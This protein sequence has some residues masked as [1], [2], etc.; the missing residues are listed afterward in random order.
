MKH[1]FFIVLLGLL[2]LLACQNQAPS[3]NEDIPYQNLRNYYFPIDQAELAQGLIYE[4]TEKHSQ[5]K[6]YW[7]LKV[8][9]DEDDVQHLVTTIYNQALEQ[10]SLNR[11]W[12]SRQGSLL[13]ELRF[14]SYDSTSKQ[15]QTFM[16]Q[17]QEEVNFP[18]MAR[19][20]SQKFYRFD[21]KYQSLPDTSFLIHFIRDRHFKG[22]EIK[23]WQDKTDSIAIFEN[24]VRIQLSN[25]SKGGYWD[26]DSMP[27]TE[28]YLRGVGLIYHR[29]DYQKMQ[30]PLEEWELTRRFDMSELEAKLQSKD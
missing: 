8:V 4:Y 1:H 13:K 3:S 30:K 27:E 10:Q 14:F 21:I 7:Y 29:K 22:L 24:K 28:H 18:F 15:T 17:H 25:A 19:S 12:L 2:N 6:E 16:A 26:M 9:P 20:D 23:T 5:R 11:E